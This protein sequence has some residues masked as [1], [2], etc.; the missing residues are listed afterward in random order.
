MAATDRR[1]TK[2]QPNEYI[3]RRL[4]ALSL[5]VAYCPLGHHSYELRSGTDRRA[6][7]HRIRMQEKKQAYLEGKPRATIDDLWTLLHEDGGTLPVCY[8]VCH[9]IFGEVLLVEVLSVDNRKY[10][11]SNSHSNA[12]TQ[13]VTYVGTK[14]GE[15]L[16]GNQTIVIEG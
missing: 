7:L 15:M 4:A 10:K 14:F 2:G 16:V 5:M 9:D 6:E 13:Y 3:K 1:L 8:M 11:S 12:H